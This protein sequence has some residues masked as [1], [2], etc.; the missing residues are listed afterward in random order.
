MTIDPIA[1][2]LTRIR[3]AS[4]I[5]HSEVVLPFSKIKLQL[6]KILEA[7]N[8]VEKVDTINT[9]LAKNSAK[10]FDELRIV[11]KYKANGRPAIS[12]LKRISKPSLRIY[13]GKDNLPV[14]LNDLGVAIL[15]TSSGLMT[16]KEA[17]I[18]KVGGE[19]LCEIY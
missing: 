8:W 5:G 10:S 14:V 7:G 1:D 15:S 17:R 18:K 3:N 6:A 12:H 4:A 9:P 13:A 11:L 2:M 16:N 19:V